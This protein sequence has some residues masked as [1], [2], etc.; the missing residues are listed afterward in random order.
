MM[1]LAYDPWSHALELGLQFVER[2]LPGCRRGEYHHVEGLIVISPGLSQRE[3]RCT[4][5]HEVQHALAG[6]VAP[7]L[8]SERAAAYRAAWMLIDPLEYAIAEEL[9]DG[10]HASIAYELNVTPRVVR[11]WRSSLEVVVWAA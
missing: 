7:S 6:D 11:D 8:K 2:K 5:A 3:E 4:V 9:R 10:H 1:G